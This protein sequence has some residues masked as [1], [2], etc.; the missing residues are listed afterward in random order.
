MDEVRNRHVKEMERIEAAMRKT[1]SKYLK[2]DYTK[3][4]KRMRAE[5]LEYDSWKRGGCD[6]A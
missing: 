6:K 2:R 4:L 3:A 5:L 1:K